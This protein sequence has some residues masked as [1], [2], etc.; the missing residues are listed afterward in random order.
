M[1]VSG[2]GDEG[3][4][5]IIISA[6]PGASKASWK[7]GIKTLALVWT[8]HGSRGAPQKAG[9]SSGERRGKEGKLKHESFR[10]LMEEGGECTQI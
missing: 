10:R 9:N 4:T 8:K 6:A 7:I 1:Q 3:T 2:D 5:T